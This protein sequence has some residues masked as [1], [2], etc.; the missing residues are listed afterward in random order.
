MMR[1]HYS[2]PMRHQPSD[3]MF[4]LLAKHREKR[5]LARFNLKDFVVVSAQDLTG[6]LTRSLEPT[7]WRKIAPPRPNARPS[8]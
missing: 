2:A 3:R 4:A 7:Q 5:L 6:V 1:F 8:N